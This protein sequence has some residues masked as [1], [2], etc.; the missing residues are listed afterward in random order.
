MSTERYDITDLKK[1]SPACNLRYISISKSD[2]EWHSILHTHSCA[3][4]FYVLR[5]NG[6]FCLENKEIPVA[7]GDLIFVEAM[8]RHTESSR[9]GRPLEYLVLG[10]DDLELSWCED[11]TERCVCL[12]PAEYGESIRV[13]LQSIHQEIE[14][15]AFGYEDACRHLVE[16]LGIRL[17]RRNDFSPAVQDGPQTGSKKSAVVRKYIDQ[18]FKEPLNLDTL[19][20]VVHM[21]K[22]HM[23][24]L[25]SRD[26]GISPI[27]YLLSLR[28]RESQ[29]L[30]RSTD[31]SLAQISQFTG[32][33]SPSYFSQSFHKAVGM[34]PAQYRTQ[35][36][37]AG[38]R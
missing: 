20:D 3:E 30:L 1:H 14:G 2:S 12:R 26:Y 23:S 5:G 31:H 37:Q 9:E 27:S 8:V 32:F 15:K 29:R 4:L 13:C 10:L 38:S 18:H 34:S 17:M 35:E 6:Y 36:K 11:G 21:N 33:S 7:A 24:H 22:Y 19:A 16:L 28:I 25:F